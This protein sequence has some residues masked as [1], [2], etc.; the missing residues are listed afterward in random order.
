MMKEL[1][2]E[3]DTDKDGRVCLDELSQM[4]RGM[5]KNPASPEKLKVIETVIDIKNL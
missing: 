5:P 2:E 4:L 1:F 3:L